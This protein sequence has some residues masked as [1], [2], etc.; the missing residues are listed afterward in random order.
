M[1]FMLHFM[2]TLFDLTDD[3]NFETTQRC[4]PEL[5][6]RQRSQ[7]KQQAEKGKRQTR[8]DVRAPYLSQVNSSEFGRPRYLP[9]LNIDKHLLCLRGGESR[10]P[11]PAGATQ[12]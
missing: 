6:G 9:R 1:N 3:E 7:C 2:V 5:R 10:A 8:A 4:C 11:G 12:N